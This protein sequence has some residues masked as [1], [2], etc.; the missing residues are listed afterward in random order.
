M[1]YLKNTPNNI[2][3]SVAN[4]NAPYINILF[5]GTYT[6]DE[7]IRVNSFTMD[8]KGRPDYLIG[9]TV[10]R[11]V[12]KAME[13][14]INISYVPNAVAH[15][16]SPNVI[17][18][19]IIS[20]GG[21][22][23][24]TWGWG[25]TGQLA[26]KVVKC[27][28]TQYS[29]KFDSNGV[30]SYTLTGVSRAVSFTYDSVS[31]NLSL[32]PLA[33]SIYTIMTKSGLD[34]YY[35]F[36][37]KD[38]TGKE[39][40]I[41]NKSSKLPT[42]IT[43]TKLGS[44][45]GSPINLLNGIAVAMR[46]KNL[47]TQFFLQV[48]DSINVTSYDNTKT[49]NRGTI[50]ITEAFV[51]DNSGKGGSLFYNSETTNGKPITFAWGAPDSEVLSWSPQF[52]G[53]SLILMGKTIQGSAD[54]DNTNDVLSAYVDIND[55]GVVVKGESTKAA[56]LNTVDNNFFTTAAIQA[57]S[58]ISMNNSR[59]EKLLGIYSYT[60]TLQV[61]GRPKQETIGQ[62]VI[63]VL[64]LIGTQPHHSWGYYLVTGITD[65]ISRGQYTTTYTLARLSYSV[66]SNGSRNYNESSLGR[67]KTSANEGE[68]PLYINGQKYTNIDAYLTAA[69]AQ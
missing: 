30:L 58:N 21:E 6:N 39:H 60:A 26:F 32:G 14:T 40:S 37:F 67:Y 4:L 5:N 28:I 36:I 1:D 63:L 18:E 12:A 10:K 9:M 68:H 16:K 48:D 38:Y 44:V 31:L 15:E 66:N 45:S 29:A 55:D 53:S 52:E 62:S 11:T 34:K 24:I 42:D 17:E 8:S 65:E 41:S 50:Y 7:S 47:T 33:S 22:C 49:D 54:K 56:L 27:M 2:K 59:I 69:R 57:M 51:G 25:N 20:S 35:K 3:N 61:L 19:A 64:P 43:C 13:V 23:Y 46:R